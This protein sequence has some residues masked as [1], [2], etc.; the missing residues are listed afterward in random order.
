MGLTFMVTITPKEI[1]PV[2]EYL[3]SAFRCALVNSSISLNQT[4]SFELSKTELP[5]HNVYKRL[6]N[7]KL[8]K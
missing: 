1:V 2:P 8:A 3:K 6:I 7:T 4:M 5:T